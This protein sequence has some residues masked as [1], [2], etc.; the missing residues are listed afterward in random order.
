M[1]RVGE[2][3]LDRA[4]GMALL[5]VAGG[6]LWVARQYPFDTLA[7]PGAGIFP[8]FVGAVWVGLAALQ[9]I[10]LGYR[11]WH[12]A[13]AVPDVSTRTAKSEPVRAVRPPLWMVGV[14]VLYLLLMPRLGFSFTTLA[15]TLTCCKLMGARGWMAP[16]ALA[17]GVVLTCHAIFSVWLKVPLPTGLVG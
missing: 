9:V 14:L 7:N 15:L 4:T 2:F 10:Y 12:T 13:P 5:A 16:L 11:S 3:S 6:Y 17:S 1:P 8:R